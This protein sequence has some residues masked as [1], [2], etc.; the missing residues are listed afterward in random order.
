MILN[1]LGIKILSGILEKGE[2]STPVCYLGINRQAWEVARKSTRKEWTSDLLPSSSRTS[3]PKSTTL[4][5]IKNHKA[6]GTGG[7]GVFKG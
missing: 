1:P 7:K 2:D 3:N 4:A 6:M 5:H